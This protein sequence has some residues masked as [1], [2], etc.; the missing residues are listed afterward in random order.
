MLPLEA[1]VDRTYTEIRLQLE[2]AGTPIGPNG[3]L[4]AAQALHLGL[5]VLTDSADEFARVA[6]LPVENWLDGRPAVPE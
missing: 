4:I 2:Q 6:G 1:G 3:L 5:T